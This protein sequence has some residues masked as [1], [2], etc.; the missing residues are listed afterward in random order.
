L[1][2]RF[3]STVGGPRTGFINTFS[4][5]VRTISDRISEGRL[6]SRV[7]AVSLLLSPDLQA[8]M[9]TSRRDRPMFH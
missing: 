8:L 5:P 7:T 2:I 9:T 4:T 1:P 6:K 3:W